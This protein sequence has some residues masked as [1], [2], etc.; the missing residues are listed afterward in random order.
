L[1]L[2]QHVSTWQP[3]SGGLSQMHFWAGIEVLKYPYN[4]YVGNI[5]I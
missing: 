2:L 1:T 5:I 3:T 4:L